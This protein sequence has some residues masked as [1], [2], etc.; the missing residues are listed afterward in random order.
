MRLPR[1]VNYCVLL[2]LVFITIVFRFP[3]GVDHEMGS[4]TTFVHTMANSIAQ[5]GFAKW[6]LHPSS[7]F[8]LYALS[9]PSAAPFVLSSVFL[10]SGV[11]IEG[12][13]FLFGQILAIIGV[14]SAF[15]MAKLIRDDDIFAHSVALLFTLAPFYVKDT[16][17]VA[18][19]RGFVVAL[20]PFF[21]ILLIKHM[22]TKDIRYLILS[23]AVFLIL[24]SMHRMGL[25][26]I[27]IFIAYIL[28]LPLHLVTQRLRFS[29]I[30]FE[31]PMRFALVILAMVAFLSIFYI[32]FQFPGIS[33]ADV[34]EQYETG[35]FLSGRNFATLLINMGVSF[36]GRV[37][38]LLL[39]APIGLIAYVWK[40]PKESVDK[41]LLLVI[42]IFLPLLSL[43]DYIIEFVIPIFTLLV[44]V[45]ALS[46]TMIL[47][48]RRQLSTV[49]LAGLLIASAVFSWQTKDRWRDYYVTDKPIPE[50]VYET[51]L[52][53]RHRGWGTMATN[54]G[55]TG[56][57]LAAI[58]GLPN[59]PMGGA[60]TH[61][62]SP[63]QL[64]WGFVD[65]NSL[66]VRLVNL[67]SISF[68]TDEIY[69]PVHVANAELHWELIFG[70]RSPTESRSLMSYY[71]VH[72]VVSDNSVFPYY[73]S[74]GYN[75][76]SCLLGSDGLPPGSPNKVC[77]SAEN[78]LPNTAY[79][80][81]TNSAATVWL[82]RGGPPDK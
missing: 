69:V 11:P 77:T 2:A 22:K 56:G 80:V 6:I 5:D 14:L 46:L 78:V 20:L 54:A 41:F 19:S 71:R 82:A 73:A 50:A 7:Y 25:L 43:R 45:G 32:Q 47:R 63:Q 37:G 33:G 70:F 66:E 62:L 24:G 52:Y 15:I 4:D 38:L 8:G 34:V 31:K 1:K 3:L 28:A 61:F 44:V 42:F 39:L 40:R 81:F 53:L 74:Y 35:V 65:G 21:F 36:V 49:F 29:L 18:S 55:L 17:W 26:V 10:V 60:S 59:L 48:R 51:A 57:R 58:S 30:K 27:L 9:Y 16:A 23:L 12:V 64:M 72:F 13:V 79:V 68:N 76:I 75:R 67:T